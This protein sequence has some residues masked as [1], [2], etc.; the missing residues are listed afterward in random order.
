[1]GR[2]ATQNLERSVKNRHLSAHAERDRRG[3]SAGDA[4]AYDQHIC[5]RSAGDAAQ[6]NTTP[7]R[8]FFQSMG[9]D[10]RREASSDLSQIGT[11]RREKPASRNGSRLSRRDS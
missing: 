2:K 1:M 10:L 11:S 9:A 6:E 8:L 4:A 3:V 5:C 7:T